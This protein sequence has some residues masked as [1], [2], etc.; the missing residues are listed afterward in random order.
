MGGDISK[1]ENIIFTLRKA[2]EE[3][4]TEDNK[5]VFSDFPEGC[6]E[7][8]SRYIARLLQNC[9]GV[10]DISLFIKEKVDVK[11]NGMIRHCWLKCDNLYIDIT[12]DQFPFCNRKVIID[13]VSSD[14]WHEQHFTE[15]G[16]QEEIN[17]AI[18]FDGYHNQAVSL[19]DVY[20]R[21]LEKCYL[22]Y[23]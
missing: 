19:L 12:A 7:Y 5:S 2:F 3:I 16:E 21:L 11:T 6:C 4:K 22:K 14:C 23:L 20:V 17:P 1:L 15:E 13:K 18:E 9:Y 8:T 10:R